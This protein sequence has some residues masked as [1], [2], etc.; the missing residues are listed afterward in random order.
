MSVLDL[1]SKNIFK[2]A[3]TQAPQATILLPETYR[4][5][6]LHEQNRC[7]ACETCVY[8]CSPGAIHFDRSQPDQVSW[9]YE[10]LQCT[11]CGRCV[12]YCPTQALSFD[13]KP[14]KCVHALKQT[15]HDIPY[16]YCARCGEAII[17]LPHVVLEE[18]YGRPVPAEM[19][20][21]NQLC[22]RCKKISYSEMI[23]RGFSG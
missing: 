12:E 2:R 15:Q 9:V 11:F 13:P 19:E 20:Q 6:L 14:I 7:T 16:Q 18:K 23:K 10:L 1:I 3:H 21:L 8:V 17:S 22:A 4:G 5:E